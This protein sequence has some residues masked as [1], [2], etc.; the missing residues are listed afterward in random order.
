MS[1]LS[2][3]AEKYVDAIQL[4]VLAAYSGFTVTEDVLYLSTAI[5]DTIEDKE[6]LERYIMGMLAL[7][8][9]SRENSNKALEAFRDIRKELIGVRL[10]NCYANPCLIYCR[11][12]IAVFHCGRTS[13][14]IGV[15]VSSQVLSLHSNWLMLSQIQAILRDLICVKLLRRISRLSLSSPNTYQHSPNGGTG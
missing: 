15:M 12:K 6:D 9:Q 10:E 8:T 11:S 1:R 14:S 7:A 3:Q 2:Q 5:Q 13:T 4:T